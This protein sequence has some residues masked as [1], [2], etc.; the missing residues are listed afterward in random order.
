MSQP[1]HGSHPATTPEPNRQLR[2]GAVGVIGILFF[3]LSAQ[4]PLTGIA[5]ALPLAIGLG[6]GAGAPAAYL[7]VG[8]V[9]ALFAVG[10]ITM[11]RH[12]TDS[13]AFY[14]YIGRVS[15][16]DSAP[17][18]HCSPCGPTT[19]SRPRC[20]ASTASSSRAC[21][22]PICT[23]PR[24]GGRAALVTMAL[25][26]ILGSLN[27]DLGA[28]FLAV[29]VG[30]EMAI[31]LAFALV[32]LLTGGGPEGLDPG[33]TFSPSALLAG[34]PGIA[35]VFAIA[36]MFGFES[37]AI[38]SAEAKDPARTVPRATYL[39]VAVVATF[40]AFVSWMVV[41]AYGPSQI[42][43]EAGKALQ[44]GDSTSLLFS[45]MSDA[46]GGWAGTAAGILMA[47][48]LLAG[49][50]AFHNACN[51]YKHSLGHGG[52]AAVGDHA[53]QPVRRSLGG[54]RGA[55]RDRGG[56]GRAVRRP[57]PRPDPDPVLL[58]QRRRRRR[59]RRPVL[60]D[61][62]VGGRVLP[63][64][65][66]RH[67]GVADADR[68]SPVGPPD[69]C[70][71]RPG[72]GQLRSAD[73]RI[74]GDGDPA[75]SLRPGGAG[76]R[77]ALREG[78]TPGAA[79]P[80]KP[81]TPRAPRCRGPA[82]GPTRTSPPICSRPDRATTFKE[83]PM[84]IHSRRRRRRRRRRIRR[85]SPRPAS[86]SARD[87]GSSSWRPATAIGGRTWTDHRL[88]PRPGDGRH[89]GALDPAAHLGRAHP[90]RHRRGPLAHAGPRLLDQRRH[91][92]TPA[93]PTTS[94]ASSTAAWPAA[95]RRRSSYFP[96]PYRPLL[97]GDR[98]AEV[99][100]LTIREKLEQLD[101]GPEEFDAVE[102]MWATNFSG[103]T[104]DGGY[105]QGL[106]WCALAGGSWQ[107]MFEAC[108]TYKIVGGTRGLIE[109][110][111]ADAAVEIRTDTRVAAVTAG[112]RGRHRHPR[113]REQP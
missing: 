102:G 37:T 13:G 107:L 25:V 16:G 31:L 105:A 77:R 2:R 24:R 56:A 108:A 111:A 3:V 79:T 57:R 48:S 11:S 72:A 60:P 8:I 53:H 9:I 55:D 6:N 45:A 50:L 5:G 69:R 41:S 109:A 26:Q 65:R 40:F 35:L 86:C 100:T 23:S 51:R 38:Y 32:T 98:L 97:E 91:A 22:A 44:S 29:L 7:V 71:R 93:P 104:E 101:L 14:S 52:G 64:D 43:G 89:L 30:A 90:L 20:T 83:K 47:T 84:S 15:A 110:M 82:W 67:P 78:G 106:R 34:A 61:V 62:G 21:A 70:P 1:T 76:H 28:R 112:R 85:R 87:T 63:Q 59:S 36:S 73:R 54:Q 12:V 75:D 113:G 66:G 4:A 68:A 103:R 58:G 92:C 80:A 95:P 27:I 81:L 19:S 33:A 96:Q 42:A 39:A 74:R 88:G 17:G 49:I 10:F 46:L 18:R 94:W 99:D